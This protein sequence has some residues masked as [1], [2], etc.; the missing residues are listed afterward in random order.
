[1]EFIRKQLS[2]V[3]PN[4]SIYFTLNNWGVDHDYADNRYHIIE[5]N[6][7]NISCLMGYGES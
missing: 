1:M 2:N 5:I 3:S 7:I 4:M 6:E